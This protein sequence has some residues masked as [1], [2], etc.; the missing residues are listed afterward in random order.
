[1]R[2]SETGHVEAVARI[3]T[4]RLTLIPATAGLLCTEAAGRRALARSLG[5]RVPAPWPPELLAGAVAFF[6]DQLE[7]HPGDAGWYTWYWIVGV[8]GSP[9]ATLVGSGGFVGPPG[10][11]GKVEVGYSVLPESQGQGYAT[12]ALVALLGWAFDHLQVLSVVAET[13][14]DNR[15]SLRILE[16][17]GFAPAGAGSEGSLVRFEMERT[18]YAASETVGTPPLSQAT[19]LDVSLRQHR[20][21]CARPI[22]GRIAAD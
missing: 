20:D 16:K 5:A 17:L 9:E 10:D 7:R 8:A 15:P 21:L 11:G 22:G 4:P 2:F 12:E 6:R 19:G 13:E 14:P 1:M 18:A 3:V